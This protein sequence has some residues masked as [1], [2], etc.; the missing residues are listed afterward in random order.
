MYRW[1]NDIYFLVS[2]CFLVFWLLVFIS[3]NTFQAK[4]CFVVHPEWL[5]E[6][7]GNADPVPLT[8]P[9]WP[10]E[11]PRYRVN[12]QTPITYLSPAEMKRE[13]PSSAPGGGR[14]TPSD[15]AVLQQCDYT[16]LDQMQFRNYTFTHPCPE[17]APVLHRTRDIHVCVPQN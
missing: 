16:P 14:W 7:A 15:A 9:P 12:L 13:R 6:D 4:S 10:W 3:Q 5:S 2:K 11:Q 8:R 17:E 1:L